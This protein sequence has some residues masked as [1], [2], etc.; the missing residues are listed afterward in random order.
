MPAEVAACAAVT[1]RVARS[2]DD[3]ARVFALRARAR[4]GAVAPLSDAYDRL[5]NAMLL[6][7]ESRFDGQALGTLRVLTADR[8]PMMVDGLLELPASLKCQSI[9]EGSRLVVCEGP[10][11]AQVRRMLWKAFHRYCLAAQVQAMLIAA[12]DAAAREYQWLGFTDV[13]PDGSLFAPR[14]RDVATHRLM[15]LGVFEAREAMMN[16]AHPLHEFFFVERHPEIDLLGPG[17]APR[18][19][20]PIPRA[21]SGSFRR[22]AD[23]ADLVVV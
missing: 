6:L 3:R 12:R 8:G 21:L 22:A 10:H 13:F 4:S 11:E 23:L 20:S 15:C 2:E 14:G 18:P 19:R 9:A 5:P 1:V 7:A 16:N 17:A